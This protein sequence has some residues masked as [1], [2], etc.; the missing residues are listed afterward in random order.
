MYDIVTI[1]I[2]CTKEDR[3]IINKLYNVP[4]NFSKY[5][6]LF[7]LSNNINLTIIHV[8][9]YCYAYISYR[10]AFIVSFIY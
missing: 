10:V 7:K 1:I 2:M 6:E 8:V 3:I 4:I 5:T 9:H